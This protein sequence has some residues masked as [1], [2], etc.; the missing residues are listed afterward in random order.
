MVARNFFLLLL[1]CSAWPCLAV[2]YQNLHTFIP[3][4]V[5]DGKNYN[6]KISEVPGIV[7][8]GN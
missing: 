3:G 2:A 7:D 1:N 4:P 8:G 6:E 5:E